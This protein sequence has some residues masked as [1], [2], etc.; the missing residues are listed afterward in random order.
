M[1]L[2]KSNPD[3]PLKKRNVARNIPPTCDDLHTDLHYT[4][5]EKAE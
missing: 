1:T 2:R 3:I 4:S 5:S